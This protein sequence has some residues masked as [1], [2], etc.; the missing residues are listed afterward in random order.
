MLYTEEQRFGYSLTRFVC[1]I[2][3]S[4]EEKSWFI[5]L[6]AKDKQIEQFME[7]GS[8]WPKKGFVSFI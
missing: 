8:L 3:E 6:V 2:D 5:C 7:L 1:L 4:K